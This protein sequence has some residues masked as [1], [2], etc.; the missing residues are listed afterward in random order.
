MKINFLIRG[1]TILYVTVWM[2]SGCSNATSD[3]ERNAALL[4]GLS[5]SMTD[6]EAAL[7]IIASVPNVKN[8]T[9]NSGGSKSLAS[10]REML[11][12]I[13]K[14]ALSTFLKS[15]LSSTGLHKSVEIIPDDSCEG[16]NCYI[17]SGTANCMN[18]GSQTFNDVKLNIE[19]V[20]VEGNSVF[21]GSIDG[22]TTY[23]KCGNK[24]QN[25]LSYPKF[26]Y[27]IINGTMA[28]N[29][30]IAVQSILSA[31]EIF[32]D[33]YTI[34]ATEN[35]SRT[36]SSESL[37]VNG[38]VFSQVKLTYNTDLARTSQVS[39]YTYTTEGNILKYSGDYIET[40]TGHVSVDG[41]LGHGIDIDIDRFFNSETF[42]YHSECTMDIGNFNG[43]C[44]VSKM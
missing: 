26:T 11:S 39:N 1:I 40:I 31:G 9:S 13:N 17:L 29:D 8:S 19:M 22:T 7:S 14:I 42:R 32:S 18:G 15:E 5:N 41:T 4:L 35:G 38:I 3:T 28:Q 16:G 36:V 20:M 21:T 6:E 34:S 33:A 25:W 30:Q 43:S 27:T 2:I 12:E 23:A 44:S 37:S 10:T 24:T